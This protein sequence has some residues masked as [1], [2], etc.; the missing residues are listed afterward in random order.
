MDNEGYVFL[1]GRIKEIIN[2]GGEK[3]SPREIDEVLLDHP[4]VAQAVTF[5]VPDPNLGEDLAAAVVLRDKAAAT[6][7]EIRDFMAS[8]VA[9]FK[10]PVRVLIVNEIPKGPTGKISRLGL[11]KIL[12]VES[13]KQSAATRPAYAEPQTEAEIALAEMWEQVLRVNHIGLMDNFFHLGGDSLG[14][15]RVAA[16]V[17]NVFNVELSLIELYAA[18]TL[19]EQAR[20]LERDLNCQTITDDEFASL[21]DEVEGE[22]CS[23]SSVKANALTKTAQS[24][25]SYYS[26]PDPPDRMPPEQPDG[27]K[28]VVREKEPGRELQGSK[29]CFGGRKVFTRQQAQSLGRTLHKPQAISG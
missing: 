15:T 21:L 1:T 17:R 14:I 8:R 19:A 24:E 13:E 11:A 6:E 25:T 29:L 16:R 18:P 23:E 2:R 22:T 9:H 27:P 26:A 5:P 7:K 12:G 3:I 28:W 10:I 4:A 20:L